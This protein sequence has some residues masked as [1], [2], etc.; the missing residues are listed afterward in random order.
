MQRITN[1]SATVRAAE[2]LDRH[3]VM[4]TPRV[5]GDA[6][7]LTFVSSF[8]EPDGTTVVGFRPC[9]SADSVSP[10]SLNAMWALAQPKG[11]PEFLF[12]PKFDWRDDELY[13]VDVASEAFGL[14][15]IGPVAR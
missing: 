12:M 11:A 3:V 2:I 5:I 10:H 13:L 9:Y 1:I 7:A 8:V 4:F 6:F 15:S 14:L